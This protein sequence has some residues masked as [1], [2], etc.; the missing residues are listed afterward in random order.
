MSEKKIYVLLVDCGEPSEVKAVIAENEDE[1]IKKII[2]KEDYFEVE[3]MTLREIIRSLDQQNKT[4]KMFS[5]LV[6]G[7]REEF[8]LNMS[9]DLYI[10]DLYNIKGYDYNSNRTYYL[11]V[12]E[13]FNGFD[14]IQIIS[15]PESIGNSVQEVKRRLATNMAYEDDFRSYVN[16]L[17]GDGTLT[18]SRF[19]LDE[20]EY[21]KAK[22]QNEINETIKNKIFK[23]FGHNRDYAVSFYKYF[24]NGEVKEKPFSDK[25]YEYIAIREYMD[26][27]WGKYYITKIK[28]SQ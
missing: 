22:D 26:Y 8:E 13:F 11:C 20:D 27:G 9:K 12:D 16:H 19:L 18:N 6:N 7:K 10:K 23:Y 2:D 25:M 15:L 17:Q 24:L 21:W 5:L 3:D 28:E 4:E 14:S 1:A